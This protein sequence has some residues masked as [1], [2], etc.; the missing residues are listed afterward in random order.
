MSP[1]ASAEFI[2]FRLAGC[3]CR[4]LHNT[5]GNT[6]RGDAVPVPGTDMPY[7]TVG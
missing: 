7:R 2:K 1:Y 4:L 3:I 5:G 6:R